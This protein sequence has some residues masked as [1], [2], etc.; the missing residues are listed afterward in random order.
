M[1]VPVYF[2]TLAADDHY[3]PLMVL[4]ESDGSRELKVA[5]N[6]Y[7]TTRLVLV[8]TGVF[9]G[10]I[11]DMTTAVIKAFGGKME[12]IRLE[13]DS[14]EL[15][16]RCTLDI[17]HSTGSCTV[18]VRPGDGVL[19]ALLHEAPIYVEEVL[20]QGKHK[21]LDLAKRLKRKNTVD[22]VRYVF[23]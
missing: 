15:V 4:K 23:N 3:Q 10:S 8:H 2:S 9:S 16:L 11:N 12:R 17:R 22:L 1:L 21:E 5:V 7:D 20:F 6:A 14:A 19:L 13:R 18:D